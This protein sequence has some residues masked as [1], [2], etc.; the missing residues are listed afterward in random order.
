[1]KVRITKELFFDYAHKL[2]N[3]TGKCSHLH[4][5]RGKIQVTLEGNEDDMSNGMLCD[6]S[7]LKIAMN[8]TIVD[9]W[10]HVYLNETFVFSDINPTAENMA[11]YAFKRLSERLSNYEGIYRVLKVRIYETPNSYAEVSDE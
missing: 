1:M 11:I 2:R 6:F 8:E 9:G 3:Y 10:D 4:G 7:D 5:H